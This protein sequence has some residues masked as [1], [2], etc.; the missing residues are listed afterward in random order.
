M[1]VWDAASLTG[2]IRI[3]IGLLVIGSLAWWSVHRK[4]IRAPRPPSQP[5]SR[6]DHH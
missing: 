1:N 6:H 3:A 4:R 5:R 2:I